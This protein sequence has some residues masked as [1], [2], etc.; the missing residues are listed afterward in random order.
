M[1]NSGKIATETCRILHRQPADIQYGRIT[2]PDPF[3]SAG[4]IH[5]RRKPKALPGRAAL[6]I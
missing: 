6:L 4:S 2:K 3:L 1:H 5:K